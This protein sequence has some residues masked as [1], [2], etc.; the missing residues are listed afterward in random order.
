MK[1]I[2][3]SLPFVFLAGGFAGLVILSSLKREPAQKAPAPKTSL[4]E[5]AAAAPCDAGFQISV[6]G[7]VT[8]Y[9]QISLAAEAAGRI[10]A[11]SDVARAGK[12]VR[13]GDLLFEIDPRDYELEVRRLRESVK[14]ASSSLDELDVEEQNAK[15][16]IAISE[17]ML[18]FDKNKVERIER[19]STR[20]AAADA[21][22]D[23]VRQAELQSLNSLQTL[24]NQLSM[25]QIRRNRLMQEK[26][27]AVTGLDQ[28]EL[29]LARTKLSSTI[30]GVVIQDFAEQDDF[31]QKGTRLIQL[32]DT[33]KV[34]V[35][36]SMRL[37]QLRWLWDSNR[38]QSSSDPLVPPTP[39]LENSAYDLPRI[40]VTVRVALDGNEFSWPARLDRYD[41][42]G[43]DAGTRTVPV[44]AV[45]EDPQS[46]TRTKQSD[47]VR[48]GPPPTL[49]RGTFVSVDIPVGQQMNLV[50]IPSTAMQPDKTVWIYDNGKLQIEPVKVAYSDESQVI[51]LA[52]PA[53]LSPGTSV[54]TSPLSVAEEGMLLRLPGESTESQDEETLADSNDSTSKRG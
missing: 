33:S 44:I 37:D 21:D 45:V 5:V 42:G 41:G 17:R 20:N 24:K 8:P 16:L 43:I 26:E 48:L 12:Y 39:D 38:Q 9:R 54:I 29:N 7:E 49:L 1:F 40:P 36:F 34:E 15:S 31:V 28:A 18:V 52:D 32:E 13:T 2:A 22:L 50:A 3:N 6:D 4:V 30:D 46:A 53:T 25:I 23:T 47:V 51:V 35:R 11:K 19:L 14:Q 27:R 10:S